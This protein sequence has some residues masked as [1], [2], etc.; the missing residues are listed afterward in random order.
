M[1]KNQTEL[2]AFGPGFRLNSPPKLAMIFPRSKTVTV[3]DINIIPHNIQALKATDCLPSS[4]ILDH[5]LVV[6]TFIQQLTS[7]LL[8]ELLV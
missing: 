5:K 3:S 6:S 1:W 7:V 2:H 4:Q 8:Q